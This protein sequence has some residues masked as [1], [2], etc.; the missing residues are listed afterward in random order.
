MLCRMVFYL[1]WINFC[2]LLATYLIMDVFV[3]VVAAFVTVV[4]WL[5]MS[6]LFR[7]CRC[8]DVDHLHVLIDFCRNW[9]PAIRNGGSPD[10]PTASN[11]FDITTYYKN[12]DRF[13]FFPPQK[14]EF[15]VCIYLNREKHAK[16]SVEI[17]IIIRLH[18]PSSTHG[19]KIFHFHTSNPTKEKTNWIQ[20]TWS[21]QCFNSVIILISDF[22]L[23]LC[24]FNRLNLLI[25]INQWI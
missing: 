5:L 13:G 22:F 25:Q 19:C 17:I 10:K 2:L 23:V 3:I 20:N 1:D 16:H 18:S 6:L 4:A 8:H 11:C 7:C 9:Q 12:M 21:L 14:K 24:R 15:G